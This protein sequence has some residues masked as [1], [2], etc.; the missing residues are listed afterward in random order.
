MFEMRHGYT[1]TQRGLVFRMDDWVCA[2][3]VY[4]RMLPYL[5]TL[6]TCTYNAVLA[7]LVKKAEDNQV[8][9][10]FFS[11]VGGLVFQFSRE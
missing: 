7:W 11:P 10:P 8:E 5:H 6:G 3:R 4:A 1:R 2:S 9:L